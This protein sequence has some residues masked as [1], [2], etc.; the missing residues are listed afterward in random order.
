MYDTL[1]LILK[2][3]ELNSKVSFME[4]ISCRLTDVKCYNNKVVGH[5]RNMRVEVRDTT[6]I[7]EGS[8]TKWLLGNNYEKYLSLWD[9]K[10]AI[11]SLS[12]ALGVPLEMAKVVRLD[13]AFNFSMKYAPWLYMK[14]LLYIDSYHRSNIEKETLYFDRYDVQLVFYDKVSELKSCGI[15]ELEELAHLNV[16]RY[17]FRFKRVTK[18]LGEVR[19][20]SLYNPDFCLLLLDKWYKCYMDI[21]KQVEEVGLKF[22][23]I[24]N[25]KE[26]CVALCMSEINMFEKVEEAFVKKEINS[27]VKFAVLQELRRVEAIYCDYDKAPLVNELTGKIESAYIKLKRQYN[28]APARIEI[29]NKVIDSKYIV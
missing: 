7:V 13:I 14:R 3:E 27:A 20:S 1:K 22:K 19:I 11:K 29:Y 24:K 4:E 10:V 5:I 8:L 23:G 21:D 28:V 16:L 25:L 17:E 6:L 26:T 2:E 12:S 15:E 9:I 18:V